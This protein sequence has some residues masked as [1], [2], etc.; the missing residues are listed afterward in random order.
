MDKGEQN[1]KSTEHWLFR[2]MKTFAFFC[3]FLESLKFSNQKIPF[4]ECRELVK[5][6][7]IYNEIVALGSYL[8]F[9]WQK[10]VTINDKGIQSLEI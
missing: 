9:A 5:Y 10:K 3:E 4:L 6:S 7:G 8:L 1:N 2:R